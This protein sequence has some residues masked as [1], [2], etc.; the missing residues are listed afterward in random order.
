MSIPRQSL[1]LLAILSVI[2]VVGVAQNV[3][4]KARAISGVIAITSAPVDIHYRN[5]DD[6]VIGRQG[7]TGDLI[8][9]N[10]EITTGENANIQILLQDQTVFSMG[11]NSAIIFDEFIYDPQ[12]GAEPSLTATVTKGAFKFISGK[13]SQSNPDAMTLKLPNAVASIRGTAVAGQIRD[14]GSS[15]LLLLS[16]AI[17][18]SSASN[19]NDVDIFTSGWG[20]SISALGLAGEPEQFSPDQINSIISSVEFS[21]PVLAETEAQ[22]SDAPTTRA[23]APLNL[24][25][26][27]A[28]ID[29]ADSIEE[30]AKAIAFVLQQ[31]EDGTVDGR[32]LARLFLANENLLRVSNIDPELLEED[33]KSSFQIDAQ[34]VEYAL[35][36]GEPKWLD[37][38]VI[39]GNSVMGNLSSPGDYA[40]LISEVYAGAVHFQK[41]GLEL[42]AAHGSGS[43]IADYE[44]TVDYDN[45]QISGS[46]SVYNVVLGGRSYDDSLNDSFSKDVSAG[47]GN[48]L[49]KFASFQPTDPPSSTLV[50]TEHGDENKNGILDIGERFESVQVT[51]VN[52][53]DSNPSHDAIVRMTGS[54]GSIANAGSVINGQL[55]G[56]EVLIEEIDLTDV[57]APTYSENIIIGRH[58]SKGTTP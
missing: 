22:D 17:T 15:D 42:A 10:D 29:N 8:Y 54:I 14:D 9:L 30:A 35:S 51:T 2:M 55:G 57:G 18:V 38:R 49:Y 5:H 27:E 34:L 58:Y 33:I 21:E 52:L 31:D 32:D 43:G 53:S 11:P 45:M 40:G 44:M 7:R 6:I 1:L 37:I 48:D 39:D 50:D 12:S 4:A 36:G 16:G 47:I 26:A 13:V 25:Q 56:V 3:I 23:D 20:V 46:L 28:I 24:E 41:S 19:Q